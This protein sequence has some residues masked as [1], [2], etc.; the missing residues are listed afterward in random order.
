MNALPPNL[1]LSRR[2]EHSEIQNT[3]D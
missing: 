2:C 1:D 3:S